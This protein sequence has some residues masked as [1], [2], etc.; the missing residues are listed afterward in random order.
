MSEEEAKKL[1]SIEVIPVQSYILNGVK[2]IV[3]LLFQ[4]NVGFREDKDTKVVDRPNFDLC[5]VLDCY[6]EMSNENQTILKSATNTILEQLTPD[7]T[8]SLLVYSLYIIKFLFI[9]IAQ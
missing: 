2:A 1:V 5:I 4:I 9:K 8:F 6:K 3:P 7:D